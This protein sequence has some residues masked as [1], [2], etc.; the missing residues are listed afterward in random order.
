MESQ[1]STVPGTWAPGVASCRKCS[2]PWSCVL[3]GGSEGAWK[4]L[5]A[6]IED[7]PDQKFTQ[8]LQVNVA[9]GG[10]AGD[11]F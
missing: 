8:M 7:R 10:V 6:C 3:V 1:D 4:H 2:C 9:G 5:G 11:S